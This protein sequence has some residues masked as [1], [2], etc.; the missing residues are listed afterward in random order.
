MAD[1]NAQD[2]NNQDAAAQAAAAAAAQVA[3]TK[4]AEAARIEKLEKNISALTDTVTGYLQR[5]A[6][7]MQ[8]TPDGHA[9]PG[10][11]P[12][13]FRN[14]LRQQGLSDADIDANAPIVVPFLAAMLATDGQVLAQGVQRV[15]D[16]VAMVKAARNHKKYPFWNELE[17]NITE[18]REAAAKQGSYLSPEDAY[19][20]AVAVDVAATESKIEAAK[21]RSKAKAAEAA[22][23]ASVQDSPINHGQGRGAAR[24]SA[25]TAEDIASMSREDRKKL[26]EQMGDVPIR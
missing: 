1:E 21:M 23:D 16:E 7:R 24:R 20:A 25:M 9:K 17:D 8:P 6:Q 18:L 10:E 14:L 22:S 11:V 12:A 15:N 5:D 4:A 13:H 26:F 19:K 3:A 2:T